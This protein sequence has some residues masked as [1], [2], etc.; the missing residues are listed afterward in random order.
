MYKEYIRKREGLKECKSSLTNNY[1]WISLL[2]QS[3]VKKNYFI[4]VSVYE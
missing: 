1:L 3:V 2:I 4:F